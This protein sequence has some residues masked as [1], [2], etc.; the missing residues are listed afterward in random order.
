[1]FTHRFMNRS[2]LVVLAVATCALGVGMTISTTAAPAS[3]PASTHTLVEVASTA[4][5]CER[6]R[7][8]VIGHRG[9]GPGT[10][11]LY[12]K[13]Y[14]EDTIGAFK[15]A[16]R[17]DADGFETDFW[18]TADNEVVSHH[19]ATVTRMTD[20]DGAIR[21]RTADEVADLRN[22]SHARV[23]TFREILRAMLP[24]H[25]DVHLQQE[26]KDGRL[27]SDAV[28]LK[29]AQLDREF[30]GDVGARVLV[31]SSQ[32]STLMR[33]HQ[34]APDLPT[35]L[36]ER[37]SGRPQLSTL[38]S[39]VDV[40]L[41]ELGAADAT[42]IRRASARGHE[43]SVRE[44]NSVSRLREAVRMG[45]TRVVTDRPELLGSAC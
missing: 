17:A 32:L 19:D 4:A 28:L 37:S 27:F 8:V 29:L 22:E 11:A 14:S 35:G 38:P 16:V 45:A 41:I 24:A 6:D 18:P 43:V 13:A 3:P 21:S 9:I 44:V 5:T 40:I 10:R 20:G 42:Y 12:G 15:A 33:F 39:W 7:V 1:M 30:V 25:P 36:I 2:T 26:F 23:P 34:L 31:T